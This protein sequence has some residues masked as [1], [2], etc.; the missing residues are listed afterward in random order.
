MQ[1]KASTIKD[2]ERFSDSV[3]KASDIRRRQ[4]HDTKSL[5]NLHGIVT[6][7]LEQIRHDNCYAAFAQYVLDACTENFT[8]I[9]E[10]SQPITQTKKDTS[11]DRKDYKKNRK[12]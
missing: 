8:K 6:K 5:D 3:K 7:L 4:G 12:P 1:S 11:N 2:I 10:E 9:K